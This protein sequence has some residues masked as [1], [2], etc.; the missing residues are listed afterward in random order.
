MIGKF[1][2]T[3]EFKI[4][5]W[6]YSRVE[7]LIQYGDSFSRNKHHIEFHMSDV[8][9]YFTRE[10]AVKSAKKLR[11]EEIVRWKK[12]IESAHMNIDELVKS[13]ETALRI[14]IV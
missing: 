7:E 5:E 9:F 8:I 10:Y 6:P 4:L 11:D 13:I 3:D 12:N 1:P 14:E 2:V